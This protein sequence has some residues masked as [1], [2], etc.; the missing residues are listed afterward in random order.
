[1]GLI[2]ELAGVLLEIAGGKA[3]DLGGAAVREV[4]SGLGA[5]S[6]EYVGSA[7]GALRSSNAFE[8]LGAPLLP[9]LRSNS[10]F[11]TGPGPTR[12]ADS[13]ETRRDG[14]DFSHL[15]SVGREGLGSTQTSAISLA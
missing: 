10:Q 1:M 3:P 8:D 5:T 11:V 15:G 7:S 6:G 2:E 12:G 13:L 4:A 14:T 9:S